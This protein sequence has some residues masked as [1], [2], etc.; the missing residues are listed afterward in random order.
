MSTPSLRWVFAAVLSLAC[1]PDLGST[2]DAGFVVG[3][4]PLSTCGQRGGS[5]CT[6]GP[7]CVGGA[8]CR[9]ARCV[10]DRPRCAATG[11]ANPDVTR[12]VFW[13]ETSVANCVAIPP[14]LLSD[15]TPGFYTPGD[16]AIGA[17]ECEGLTPG[18]RQLRVQLH[19]RALAAFHEPDDCECSVPV[20][21]S[22][23]LVVDDARV[24][25][26]A[27]IRRENI[28]HA[29]DS[30]RRGPDEDFTFPVD[31]AADGRFR[32]RLDL[33]GCLRGRPTRCLFVRGTAMTLEPAP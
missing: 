10:A 31:V 29:D 5:C 30:C 21:A 32:A 26:L 7:A 6:V 17:L 12:E 28:D 24:P 14:E 15:R 11:I 20:V 2:T 18:P 9:D 19:V 8:V 1:V 33:L 23:E 27:P 3:D 4:A 25:A 16:R 13:E 22:I